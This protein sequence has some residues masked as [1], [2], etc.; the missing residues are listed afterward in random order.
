MCSLHRCVLASVSSLVAF[1]IPALA[2]SS[3]TVGDSVGTRSESTFRESLRGGD[4]VPLHTI[5]IPDP[6]DPT[7]DRPV[8]WW[9]NGERDD[10]LLQASQSANGLFP[11]EVRTADDLLLQKG[12]WYHLQTVTVVLA[13]YAETPVFALEIYEDCDGKPGD[14]L[15]LTGEIGGSPFDGTPFLD[16]SSLEIAVGTENFEGLVFYEVTFVVNGFVDGYRR[17][18]V[19]PYGIGEDQTFWVSANEGLIQGVKAQYKSD[20]APWEDI[21]ASCVNCEPLCTDFVFEVD[22]QVCKV[23][24]DNSNFETVV[25][26]ALPGAPNIAAFGAKYAIAA[27]DDFQVPQGDS[28]QICKLQVWVAAN[29]IELIHGSLYM[30]EC[31]MPVGDPIDL[32]PPQEIRNVTTLDGVPAHRGLPVYRV[33]WANNS[34]LPDLQP[35]RNMW[36]SMGFHGAVH[37]SNRAYWLFTEQTECEELNINPARYRHPY[38][39]VPVF[40]SYEFVFGVLQARDHAFKLWVNEDP[41]NACDDGGITPQDTGNPVTPTTDGDV[42]MLFG[43]PSAA[44]TPGGGQKAGRVAR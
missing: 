44:T 22:G 34:N 16:Y 2:S 27:A 8:Q 14:L 1:G 29:C 36:L 7:K 24:K 41:E 35:G 39:G 3:V 9:D 33:T 11:F 21:D 10:R 42:M 28:L 38:L 23:L 18:W 40:T 20:D 32:G 31:D 19:S 17:L 4:T 12:C 26:P 37:A 6:T 15:D 30:N 5:R 13:S 25:G 43:A